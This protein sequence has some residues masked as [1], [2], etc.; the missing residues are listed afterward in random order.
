M[1]AQVMGADVIAECLHAMFA[2]VMDGCMHA[3]FA[4]VMDADVIVECLCHQGGKI[5][6]TCCQHCAGSWSDGCVRAWSAI[7]TGSS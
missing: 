7:L 1:F 3:M 2:Q 5:T 6:P 4:Q